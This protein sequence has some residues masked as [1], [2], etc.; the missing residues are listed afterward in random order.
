MDLSVFMLGPN[1]S[2]TKQ[3]C[4]PKTV[5]YVVNQRRRVRQCEKP[6]WLGLADSTRIKILNSGDKSPTMHAVACVVRIL[7]AT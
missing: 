3:I 1:T 7:I 6:G 5:L 2:V 4:P